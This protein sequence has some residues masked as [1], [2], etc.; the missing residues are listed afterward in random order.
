V[1]AAEVV[2]RIFCRSCGQRTKARNGPTRRG[3]R[4]AWINT[5]VTCGAVYAAP[6]KQA[7]RERALER[8]GQRRLFE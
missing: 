7:P 4:W 8:A 5:C 6:S 3:G 1:K 2:V